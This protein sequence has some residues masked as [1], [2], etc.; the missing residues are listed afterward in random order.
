MIMRCIDDLEVCETVSEF[1]EALRK[2]LEE[3]GGYRVKM[4]GK[5]GYIDVTACLD[6]ETY[7]TESDGWIY[8]IQINICGINLVLRYIED[9]ITLIDKLVLE[10]QTSPQARLVFY[11]HNLGYEYYWLSQI[12]VNRYGEPRALFTNRTKPLLMDFDNGIT[13]RD[14]LKLFQK[15]LEKATEHCTHKKATGDIDH[16]QV[17]TPDSV[18]TDSEFRYIVY[19]VQGL[20]EA[21]EI[22]KSDN[23]YTQL[24]IPYTNTGR[25]RERMN[26]AIRKEKR[27]T[28]RKAMDELVLDKSQI[29]LAYKVSAGGSTHAS[30]FYAGKTVYNCN[31]YDLKSAHPSQMLL[32]PYP[33]GKVIPFEG[34]FSELRGALKYNLFGW[35][36]LLRI[37]DFH[38][39]TGCPEPT[40]SVSKAEGRITKENGISGYDNGR[41]LGADVLEVYM[42]SND[43][44]RF[45]VAYKYG[46]IEVV[47]AFLFRL[48]PLPDTFKNIVLEDFHTKENTPKDTSDYMFSKICINTYFGVCDQKQIR[49]EYTVDINFSGIESSKTKWEDKLEAMT[50]KEVIEAQ[51]NAF[52]YLWGLWTAS[53]SRLDLF[54]LICTVGWDRVVY[55][56]TDSVKYIGGKCAAIERYNERVIAAAKELNAFVTNLKGESVY[57][58]IAEDEAPDFPY[59]YDEFRALHA[60][61]YAA[62]V[63]KTDKDTHKSVKEVSAT[64]AGVSKAAG[65]KALTDPNTGLPDLSKLSTGLVIKNAGGFQL[66]YISRPIHTQYFSRETLSAS[67]IVMNP[68]TYEILDRDTSKEV[69]ELE[70]EN[71]L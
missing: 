11:V 68:R 70:F 48:K 25:V 69:P 12:L 32:K 24:S 1:V 40:I 34:D 21:I 53:L 66:S 46:K 2:I 41:V 59:Y 60:K 6:I 45:K 28:T 56:D 8:S 16:M 62:V 14:S 71:I 19:D 27:Q 18:L 10:F 9:F 20:Y 65:K 38:I 52:P 50:D 35:V 15:S 44:K 3:M 54:K 43:F 23:S 17:H 55:W 37:Y 30:R 58:G 63:N 7:A 67:Y 22:L 13:F 36:A 49:D 4:R 5:R 61:C 57:I 31:S 64:I 42:D 39:R 33:S 29:R 26:N 47:E 51:K